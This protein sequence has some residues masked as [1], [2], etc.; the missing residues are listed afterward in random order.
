MGIFGLFGRKNKDKKNKLQQ[1]EPPAASEI[2]PL[3]DRDYELLFNQILEGINHGWHQGQIQQFFERLRKRASQEQWIAWLQRFGDK[4]LKSPNSDYVLARQMVHLGGVGC[5]EI[6]KIAQEIG[7][8]LL[9]R[10]VEELGVDPMGPRRSDP[11]VEAFLLYLDEQS[12]YHTDSS[13]RHV[14]DEILAELKK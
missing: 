7:T 14:A 4:L 3:S 10:G 5:G 11:G 1:P 8:E 2:K 9:K 12:L 6:G 13:V